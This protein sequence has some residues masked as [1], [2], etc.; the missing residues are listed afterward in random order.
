LSESAAS[1]LAY[2]TFI[3]AIIFLLVAPYN[4]SPK[5]K[6]HAIQEIGLTALQIMLLFLWIIPFLG[7]LIWG[8]GSLVLLVLWVLC[9]FKASQGGAFK[10]P[11]IGSFAASQSGYNG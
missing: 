3:P 6:F 10:L 9:I 2:V 7:F 4:L 5:I 1:A 11:I 8:L